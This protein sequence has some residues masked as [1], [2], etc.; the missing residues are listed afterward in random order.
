LHALAHHV[1]HRFVGIEFRVLLEIAHRKTFVGNHLALIFLID[2]GDDFQQ[3]RFTGTIE[4]DN[5]NLGAI[6]KR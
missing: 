6:K 5:A 2:A 4:P 3:S 1:Y